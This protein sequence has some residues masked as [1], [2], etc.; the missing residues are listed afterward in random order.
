[1]L[2]VTDTNRRHQHEQNPGQF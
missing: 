1:M 2:S